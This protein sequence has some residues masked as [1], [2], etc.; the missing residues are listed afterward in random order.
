M[1]ATN[2]SLHSSKAFCLRKKINDEYATV[3]YFFTV[4]SIALSV[5]ACPLIIILNTLITIAVRT[6]RTLQ[7]MHNILLAYFMA[8]DNHCDYGN[9]E[10]ITIAV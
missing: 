8:V 1:N 2:S 7:T 5:L 3:D 9:D 4:L 6:K 10:N